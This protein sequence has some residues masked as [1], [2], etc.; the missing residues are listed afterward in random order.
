[1]TLGAKRIGRRRS[2]LQENW[3]RLLRE[4][5]PRNDVSVLC[6]GH[7]PVILCEPGLSIVVEFKQL[8][9]NL[10]GRVKF[11]IG[12]KAHELEAGVALAD[13]MTRRNSGADS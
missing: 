12:G 4:K 1:M 3:G 6:V 7:S 13:S 10:R 11:P 2:K 9:I 5:H 8:N